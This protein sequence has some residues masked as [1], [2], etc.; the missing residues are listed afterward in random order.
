MI[1][2]DVFPVTMGYKITALN[3]LKV[4]GRFNISIPKVARPMVEEFCN[5]GVLDEGEFLDIVCLVAACTESSVDF[6]KLFR[7][8][9]N[10][11]ECVTV[12]NGAEFD[13]LAKQT[14]EIF[15]EEINGNVLIP[16][17]FVSRGFV[18]YEQ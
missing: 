6:R 10:E 18:A 5:R 4:A 16:L 8:I 1:N 7:C 12:V 15:R 3:V 11:A 13:K 2:A 14:C 17:P 9:L